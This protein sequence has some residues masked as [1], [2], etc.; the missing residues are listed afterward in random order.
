MCL[1]Y[2]IVGGREPNSEGLQKQLQ[3]KTIGSICLV[4]WLR[5]AD[6]NMSLVK[7][8]KNGHVSFAFF[9]DHSFQIRLD[10]TSK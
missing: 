5:R 9:L 2:N 1:I 6:I 3:A 7:R 4:V 8:L 10:K